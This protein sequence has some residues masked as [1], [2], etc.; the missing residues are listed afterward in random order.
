MQARKGIQS[1]VVNKMVQQ[2]HKK[3]VD[4]CITIKLSTM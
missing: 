2:G 1:Y 3:S 4:P